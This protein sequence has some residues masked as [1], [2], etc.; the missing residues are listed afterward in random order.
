MR[1]T[2][3][4]RAKALHKYGSA[5][6]MNWWKAL[7]SDGTFAMWCY[8]AMQWSQE[9]R[10]VPLAMMTNKLGAILGQSLIGRGAAFG[11]QFVLLHSQG[12]V[13]NTAV[14]GGDEIFLEHQ[15]TLG[16]TRK[17]API[18][19]NRIVIGC[20]AKILGPVTIGDDVVIGANAVVVKDVP[21][22]ATVGG[23]PARIIRLAD[24]TKPSAPRRPD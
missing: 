1:I 12:I 7:T 18:L 15:V 11:R 5:S 22:G 9:R 16:A 14:R 19:G 4:I 20:G 13:I 3:D 10:L 8:R 23:I 2:E 17:G 24:D 6:T 21:A